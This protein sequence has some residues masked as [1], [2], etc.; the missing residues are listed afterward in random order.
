[1][2]TKKPRGRPPLPE[3]VAR[4]EKMMVRFRASD[5]AALKAAAG[6]AGKPVSTWA[7]E[8]LLAAAGAC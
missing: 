3:G 1:M 6:R 8:V 2:E 5:L 4:H 7:A